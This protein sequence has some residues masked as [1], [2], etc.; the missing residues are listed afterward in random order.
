MTNHLKSTHITLMHIWLIFGALII[1]GMQMTT[2]VLDCLYDVGDK[3]DCH[4]NLKSVYTLINAVGIFAMPPFPS[5]DPILVVHK[6]LNRAWFM[7]KDIISIPSVTATK[8]IT[9][10]PRCATENGIG[11][12]TSL[13]LH[14]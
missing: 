11:P 12:S 1:Y 2:K 4:K 7:Y 9:K 14:K 13:G 3:S 10:S 8:T 5:I 6:M